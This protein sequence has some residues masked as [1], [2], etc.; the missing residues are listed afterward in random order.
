[1]LAEGRVLYTG[2]PALKMQH[3]LKTIDSKIDPFCESPED[4]QHKKSSEDFDDMLRKKSVQ[5]PDGSP[6]SKTLATKKADDQVCNCHGPL[7]THQ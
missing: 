6:V 3:W 4:V 1:M 2:N 7:M 5:Q